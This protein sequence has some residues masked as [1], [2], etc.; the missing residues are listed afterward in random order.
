MRKLRQMGDS[1]AFSYFNKYDLKLLCWKQSAG[2]I[3]GKK[4][5]DKELK[6]FKS[7]FESGEFAILNDITNSLRFGDITI[8]KNGKPDII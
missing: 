5:L 3:S 7:Y 1:I 8:S 6:I 4:G 2:F